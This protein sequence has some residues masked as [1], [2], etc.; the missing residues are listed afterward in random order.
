MSVR[1]ELTQ[2]LGQPPEQVAIELIC[3]GFSPDQIADKLEVPR[4]QVM[5]WTRPARTVKRAAPRDYRTVTPDGTPLREWLAAHGVTSISAA[6]VIRRLNLGW[7]FFDAVY[8]E[9]IPRPR[10]LPR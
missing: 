7:G 5:R 1:R 2:L 10:R 4:S 6:H 9:V 3:S 8:R